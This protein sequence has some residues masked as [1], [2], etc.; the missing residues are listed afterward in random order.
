[1][2]YNRNAINSNV[3]DMRIKTIIKNINIILTNKVYQPGQLTLHVFVKAKNAYML[4][5]RK[6]NIN[7]VIVI[8]RFKTFLKISSIEFEAPI[9]IL[10][11]SLKHV[12]S[13]YI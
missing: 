3:L 9:N 11:I 10:S 6:T 5:K 1:M 4:G 7:N 8:S 13:L 2:V 12:V